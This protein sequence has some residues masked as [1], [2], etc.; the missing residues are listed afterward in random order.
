MYYGT[1]VRPTGPFAAVLLDVDGT[2]IDSAELIADSLEFA[3]RRHL[4]RTH[5][6]TEYYALIGRP[7]LVQMEILGGDKAPEMVD[8]A[9][10]YYFEHMDEERPFPGAIDLLA[11]F[12][13]QGY[14][15]G[16]V[17]SKTRRELAPTLR[18]IPIDR[19]VQVV[20]TAEQTTRP[21]PN[22][23]PIYLALQ[24]LQI[25][26]DRTLFVGDSPYDIQAGR[27]A[28]V[29][30]AAATWGPHP[31]STLHAEGPDYVLRGFRD[32]RALCNPVPYD[33]LP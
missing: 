9:I 3:C 11:H 16:L 23:D 25:S 20:V 17:T 27:A 29:K 5:P 14:R 13:E 7:A 32:L 15:L 28:G 19:Y 22:P 18:Q 8:T 24:T 1:P 10:E 2:L 31:A 33:T 30:T 26:A 12:S 4:G 6:R 21:K